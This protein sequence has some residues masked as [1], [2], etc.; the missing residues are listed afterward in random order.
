MNRTFHYRVSCVNYI[1]IFMVAAAALFFFW[2]RSAINAVVAFLLVIA[3]LL[4]IERIIHTVYLFTSDDR[5]VIDKGRFSRPL[6]VPVHD[7]ISVKTV[8]P[9]LLPVRY[10]VVEYGAGHVVSVQPVNEEAFIGEIRRRQAQG[11][12]TGMDNGDLMIFNEK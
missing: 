9:A 10:V 4:M 2:N 1:A 7:I 3:A 8:R 11:E 12:K 5:L 6:S